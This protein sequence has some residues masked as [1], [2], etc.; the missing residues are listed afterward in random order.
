MY[1]NPPSDR[2][3]SLWPRLFI[4]EH[5]D[6]K[7]MPSRRKRVPSSTLVESLW[8]LRWL[9]APTALELTE[10]D[11]TAGSSRVLLK[12]PGVNFHLIVTLISLSRPSNRCDTI[13]ASAI[14]L[15]VSPSLLQT[16]LN[17]GGGAGD[18]VHPASLQSRPFLLHPPLPHLNV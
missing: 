7:Q 14:W 2:S 1:L 12:S 16:L 13:S 10:R 4:L 18:K 15:R 11:W 3:R 9:I 5:I 6:E 17:L 8:S